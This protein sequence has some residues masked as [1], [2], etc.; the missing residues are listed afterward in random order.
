MSR[1][2]AS[3][4]HET[5]LRGTRELESDNQRE[6]QLG[7]VGSIA[8]WRLI[9]ATIGSVGQVIID[10]VINGTIIDLANY[11]LNQQ[12][13]V[14][15]IASNATGP[16]ASIRYMYA[17]KTNFRTDSV[18]PYS[19][20]GNLA[21]NVYRPCSQLVLGTHIIT[22]T[23]YSLASATG[24]KGQQN[25]VSFS[26]VKTITT[27]APSIFPSEGPSNTPSTS[28]SM[29]PSR[30]P[31]VVPT[32]DLPA[33]WIEVNP[34][35]PINARHEACFVMVGR[36]A[37]LLVGRGRQAVNIYD[38][39]SRTWT[40]GTAPPIQIHHTQCVAANDSIWI[41]SSWT[42][43]Y[44]MEKNI[45]KIYVRVLIWNR[46]AAYLEISPLT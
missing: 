18:V 45:D 1:T 14:E 39:V 40:N 42:G 4:D 37:Y 41:V 34:N 5:F 31:S 30:S 44:P 32:I 15:V 6:L 43:G 23:P 29:L 2:V 8:K 27:A 36:K 46:V 13:S 9:N 21:T 17:N 33:A 28:T 19:L 7:A 12:F 26:I 38:P 10:P 25:T 3:N 22:A 20:C 16:V 11:P 24:V 35:A